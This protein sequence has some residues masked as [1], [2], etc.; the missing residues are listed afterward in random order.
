MSALSVCVFLLC[1]LFVAAAPAEAHA[2]N[3]QATLWNVGLPQ[4]LV[5]V[6][7]QRKTFFFYEKKN[8]L[9]ARYTFPCTTGQLDGD[10]QSLND[11]RTPEGVYFV[12][13]KIAKG[14]DFKEY[15]GV[16][17]TL[18]YP[19]P[20][21]RLR[22]KT[23]HGI[24]IHSKGYGLVPTRGCVAIGLKEIDTVG[25]SL[26]PGTAVVLAEQMDQAKLPRRDSGTAAELRR[27]MQSWSNAWSARSSKMFDFYDQAAYSVATEN[28][29]AFRANKERLFKMLTYVKLVNRDIHVLEGPGYWVTWSEQFY[30]ASNHCTEGVR[31]LYW[32]RGKDDRFRIVGMEWTPRDLGMKAEY[33]KGR[34][35]AENA[36][37]ATDAASE[38]PVAPRLDMPE[39]GDGKT[40]SKPAANDGGGALVAQGENLV[41][42]S[43]APTLPP[44]EVNWGAK[45]SLENGRP[46]PPS[47]SGASA[48]AAPAE[49]QPSAPAASG[50]APVA[51]H[52][53][54]PEAAGNA[55]AAPPQPNPAE[56]RQPGAPKKPADPEPLALDDALRAAVSEQAARYDRAL[57]AREAVPDDLFDEKHY[58]RLPG[59]PRG[60]SFRGMKQDLQEIIRQPWLRVIS[61]PAEVSVENGLAVS[62]TPQLLA[63]PGGTEQ[64]ER[65]LWWNRCEDG[66]LRIVASEFRPAEKGLS[67][68]YLELISE[69]VNR[70]VE[71]WRKAWLA[72]DLDGYAAAYA[73]D[74]VQQNCV[75]AAAIRAQKKLLWERVRPAEVRLAGLRLMPDRNGVRVD[76]VQVYADTAG[77]RDRGVKTLQMRYDGGHWRIQREDWKAQAN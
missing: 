72:A 52:P 53:A 71:A 32:Q 20:V 8:P 59:L 6:D 63:G 75:G 11:L 36:A 17:Y 66:R 61:R 51:G 7:K 69:E 14:L 64:G 77:K 48:P 28:F 4:H 25:P 46:G 40:A 74:A 23:G 68:E 22:G 2:E 56:P 60:R 13:Y 44:A 12:E 16:A 38:A 21:D 57:A 73:R 27:L 67:A 42:H 15:G 24:W 70:D 19:N 33:L 3:W 9:Q 55:P 30:T 65:I 37:F 18:N 39:N 34:L 10:K 49:S 1:L 54:A 29:A 41:P 35:V 58:N 62:R 31:R 47:N 50:A 43:R 26:T 45:P 5:A 76:M